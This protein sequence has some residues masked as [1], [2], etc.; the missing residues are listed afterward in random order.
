VKDA[1]SAYKISFAEQD[2][3]MSYLP[4]HLKPMILYKI[5]TGCRKQEVVQLTW[6]ME[7][8]IAGSDQVMFKLPAS[9]TKNG[10]ARVVAINREARLAIESVRGQHDEYVF[11]Y[12]GHPVTKINNSGW[13]SARLK[14]NL[15][16]V[17]VHDLRHTFG[18]RLRAADVSFE[19]RQDLLGHKSNNITT[20]YSAAE[21]ENLI[22][23]A[24][25][26][27]TDEDGS[28]KCPEGIVLIKKKS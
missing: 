18:S 5:N 10:I 13:K 28:R 2:R 7:Y 20:D 19:D 27:C 21:M 25:M 11:T 6:D 15:R 14:A 26:I 17:R 1:R 9:L 12:R 16:Q 23:A 8:E 4:K 22:K 24:N 3:L